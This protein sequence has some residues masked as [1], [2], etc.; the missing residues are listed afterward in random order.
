[1]PTKKTLKVNVKRKEKLFTA[2][3][4]KK[5]TAITKR[6]LK[7]ERKHNKLVKEKCSALVDNLD[8]YNCTD[9]IYTNSEYK[10]LFDD[11]SAC[12]KKKCIKEHAERA[13]AYNEEL[14]GKIGGKT[15][16]RSAFK[17]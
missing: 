2:C 16:K 14:F 11:W 1:M 12:T 15:K 9:K 6:K 13:A 8:Y 4:K 17:P 3:V 5:C 10:K 7:G